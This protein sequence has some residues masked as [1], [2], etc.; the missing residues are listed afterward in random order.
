[1]KIGICG[2]LACAGALALGPPAASADVLVNSNWNLFSANY[3]VYAQAAGGQALAQQFTL[4]GNF[5]LDSMSFYGASEASRLYIVDELSPTAV[6][7]DV[8]WSIDFSS[9]TLGW[10]SFAMDGLTLSAGDYYLVMETD[11][12][13]VKAGTWAQATNGGRVGLGDIRTTTYEAGQFA[14]SNEFTPLQGRSLTLRISGEELEIPAPGALTV[15][16]FCGL[17]AVRRRRR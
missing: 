3:S 2:L 11:L 13:I 10:Q 4:A 9:T 17:A 7:G 14:A 12:G 1:M 8:L 16:G 15:A 6:R 5:S